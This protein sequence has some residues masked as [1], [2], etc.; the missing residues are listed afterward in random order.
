MNL[1]IGELVEYVEVLKTRQAHK[2]EQ[3]DLVIK[4][5]VAIKGELEGQADADAQVI[6]IL[7]EKLKSCTK[8]FKELEDAWSKRDENIA[9]W[10]K[11][12]GY[13]QDLTN[14][15]LKYLLETR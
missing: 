13:N 12:N 6:A 3:R 7:E 15:L 10:F 8:C 11:V 5:L 2:V 1:K 14:K 9:Y 4:D